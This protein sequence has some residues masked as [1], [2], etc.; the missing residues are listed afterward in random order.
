MNVS[1]IGIN[2]NPIKNNEDVTFGM[3]PK[4]KPS[5]V[6]PRQLKEYAYRST[7]SGESI[8][9]HAKSRREAHP[10]AVAVEAVNN[11]IH[12]LKN[13]SNAIHSLTNL[14]FR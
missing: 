6:K 14:Y 12:S 7:R 1:A 9:V 5:R 13:L 8:I 10:R 3:A 2:A 11:A 4:V